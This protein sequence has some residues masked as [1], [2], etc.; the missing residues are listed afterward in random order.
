MGVIAPLMIARQNPCVWHQM[1][2]ANYGIILCG[3]VS[4]GE[5]LPPDPGVEV[6]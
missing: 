6:G 3:H 5:M 1:A 4:G 2:A